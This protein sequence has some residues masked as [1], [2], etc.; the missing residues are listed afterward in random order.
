MMTRV[1]IIIAMSMVLA[2]GFSYAQNVSE[3]RD[4]HQREGIPNA[5]VPL[6][7]GVYLVRVNNHTVKTIVK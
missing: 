5:F 3:A 7:A 2:Q 6:K 4:G 1:K